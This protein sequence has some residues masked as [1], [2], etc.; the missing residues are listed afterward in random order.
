MRFS[1]S[2][3]LPVSRPSRGDVADC[4]R[5]QHT[6][7]RTRVPSA[8][9]RTCGTPCN[10]NQDNQVRGISCSMAAA[11]LLLRA[12]RAVHPLESSASTVHLFRG[13]TG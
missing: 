11:L 2:K 12:T 13:Q 8:G 3:I 6:Q 9:S 7:C 5:I 4:R 10:A 1:F